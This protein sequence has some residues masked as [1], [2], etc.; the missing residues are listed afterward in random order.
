MTSGFHLCVMQLQPDQE[1]E[2]LFSFLKKFFK[3]EKFKQTESVSRNMPCSKKKN[4]QTDRTKKK[5]IFLLPNRCQ[6]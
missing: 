2:S 4:A 1:R 6:E 5:P 3:R